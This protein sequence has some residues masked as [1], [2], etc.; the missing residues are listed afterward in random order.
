MIGKAQDYHACLMGELNENRD[1]G[2]ID[3]YW[4]DMVGAWFKGKDDPDMVLL[5]F[6]LLDAAIWA[7]TRNPI[8]MAWEVKRSQ[9]SDHEPDVGARAHVD[10]TKGASESGKRM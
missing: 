10:F 3:Q 8:K 9:N 2:K 4:N 6:D 5:E 7:S 1:R